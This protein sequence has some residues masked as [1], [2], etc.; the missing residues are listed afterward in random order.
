MREIKFRQWIGD[1]FEYWG[2]GIDTGSGFTSSFAGPCAGGNIRADKTPQCQYTGLKDKNGKEIYE[3]DLVNG[4]IGDLEVINGKVVFDAGAF[5]V[6]VGNYL[7]CLYEFQGIE[8][9]GNIY[10]NPELME[11]EQ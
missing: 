8:I 7:P 4:F 3:S 2:I 5:S 11:N 9:I 6:D 1:R 10:E